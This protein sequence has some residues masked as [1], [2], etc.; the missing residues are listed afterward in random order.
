MKALV[1]NIQQS[2]E[3]SLFIKLLL[4]I[5]PLIFILLVILMIFL[6]SYISDFIYELYEAELMKQAETLE[7][8]LGHGFMTGD[9]DHVREMIQLTGYESQV[10]SLRLLNKEGLILASS[11]PEE[12]GVFP[13]LES[14]SCIP[15]HMTESGEVMSVVH[16]RSSDGTQDA[17][18]VANRI[19]NRIACQ[20]CHEGVIATL[21]VLIIESPATPITFWQERLDWRLTA[22]GA[23]LFV[24]VVVIGTIV[25]RRLVVVPLRSLSSGISLEGE[26]QDEIGLLASRMSEL[27]DSLGEDQ[28][29]I[30]RRVENLDAI[31]SI[32]EAI[33]RTLSIPQVLSQALDTVLKVMDLSSGGMRLL[34]RERDCFRLVVHRGLTPHMVQE[35]ETIP[36]NVGFQ[37]EVALTLRPVF[38]SDLNADPRT[39]S[40]KAVEE[41]YRSL[42]CVPLLA[43]QE[44]VGIMELSTKEV[45]VWEDD[46]LRWFATI[47]RQIG[48][49]VNRIQLSEKTRDRA[50]LEERGRLSQ[51]IHDGLSQLIG[52][53]RLRAEESLYHLDA[54][55]WAGVRKGIEEIERNARDAYA[56]LREEMLGLRD[57]IVSGQDL[58][59]LFAE[60]LS[61]FQRQWGIEAKLLIEDKRP[62]SAPPAVEVQLLRIVQEAITNI[63]RHASATQVFVRL[64]QDEDRLYV[65]VKDD[66]RGF[67]TQKERE[68]SKLGLSIM[69]ERASSVG[70]KV[71]VNSIRDTGTTVHIEVPRHLV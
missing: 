3:R 8:S 44:L 54:G 9:I 36:K 17:V 7:L 39:Q 47:G 23:G 21:G 1:Q 50:V 18:M 59:S 28:K 58:V 26:R 20:K 51:E 5:T 16:T 52:S 27:V 30:S 60:F 31:L 57:T 53:L 56:S 64:D 66:G 10:L 34:D 68:E 41:G 11:V 46:E 48:V 43:G 14:E 25:V 19:E 6:S 4:L 61:R 29:E 67:D 70:G 49:A 65:S 69:H 63:R 45:R 15:C 12:A 42:V 24:L 2:V 37:G 22:G 35:L 71:T 32:S 38:T 33:G 62:Y 40:I 55:D 13:P